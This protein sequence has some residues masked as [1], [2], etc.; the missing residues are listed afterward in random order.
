VIALL[1][2]LNVLLVPTVGP[3]VVWAWQSRGT[4]LD[5][6]VIGGGQGAAD[7]SS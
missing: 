6:E 4:R 2:Q 3:V 5:R 1:Y 7:Q